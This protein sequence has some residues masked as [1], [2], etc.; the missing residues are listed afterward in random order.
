MLSIMA[1]PARSSMAVWQRKSTPGQSAQHRPIGE[2]L[3][4]ATDLT[5][6]TETYCADNSP[7]GEST[8]PARNMAPAED[9]SDGAEGAVVNVRE[10]RRQG[11]RRRD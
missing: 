10:A 1:L 5:V 3:I 6:P 8:P 7:E 2:I 4:R 11:Q 9:R